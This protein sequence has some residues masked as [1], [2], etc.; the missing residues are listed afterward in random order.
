MSVTLAQLVRRIPMTLALSGLCV[1]G[2]ITEV[3]MGGATDLATL[4]RLGAV[5]VGR[6]SE[7]G[8]VWRLVTAIVLHGGWLHLLF[9]LV[10]LVQLGALTEWI[11]GPRRMFSFFVIC[12]ISGNVVSM[13]GN[14]SWLLGQVGASGSLFGLGG[15]ILGLAWFGADPWST[16]L[17]LR[18]ARVLTF[19]LIFSLLLGT[20]PELLG[21][22]KIIDNWAHIG[23]LVMGFALSLVYRDPLEAETVVDQRVFAGMVSLMVAAVVT[24]GVQGGGALESL[25]REQAMLLEHRAE[26]SSDGLMR[27]MFVEQAAQSYEDASLSDSEERVARLIADCSADTLRPLAFLWWQDNVQSPWLGDALEAWVHVAPEDPDALNALAWSLV[28]GP[29]TEWDP[30]RAEELVNA[31]LELV[32][33]PETTYADPESFRAAALDTR[34]ESLRQQGRMGDALKNQREAVELGRSKEIEELEQMEER[35]RVLEASQ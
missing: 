12:G 25:P 10:A 2:F 29:E 3:V 24:M 14:G 5:H 17:R 35:L 26:S 1:L 4:V 27:A 28:T 34:A 16:Q 19:C 11:Y 6:I 21:L 22:P 23:G 32:A 9:N 20:I 7:H 8:E 33:D 30:V 18:V 15:V 31:A 13:M